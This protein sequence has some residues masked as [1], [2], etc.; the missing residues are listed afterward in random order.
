[1][2][3]N[4]Y[5]QIEQFG[6]QSIEPVSKNLTLN[7]RTIVSKISSQKWQFGIT[8][9]EMTESQLMALSVELSAQAGMFGEFQLKIPS[10]GQFNT[11]KT[12][13][14]TSA[15][16]AAGLDTIPITT[17]GT[18]LPGT[19]IKFSGHTKLYQIRTSTTTQITIYPALTSPLTSGETGIIDEP[20]ATVRNTD[21]MQE[22]RLFRYNRAQA[23][24]FTLEEVI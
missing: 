15:T 3:I 8:T 2:I 14:T 5:I 17:H 18:I 7:N 10:I 22:L 24:D 1:M 13:V 9:T 6:I 20:T 19:F 23:Y 12:A 4:N 21:D 11:D 16:V